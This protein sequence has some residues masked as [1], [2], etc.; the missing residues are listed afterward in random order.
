[1]E[2]PD[3]NYDPLF[4][5]WSELEPAKNLPI[6]YG[7][8]KFVVQDLSEMPAID[9]LHFRINAALDSRY[10]FDPRRN[11]I[12]LETPRSGWK[13]ICGGLAVTA[14]IA[15]N[16]REG[17]TLE[18]EFQNDDG[19]VQQVLVPNADLSGASPAAVRI[20]RD[21]GLYIPGS[22][23]DMAEFLRSWRPVR[24]ESDFVLPGWASDGSLAFGLRDGRVVLATDA[25][26]ASGQKNAF[27]YDAEELKKWKTEVASKFSGNPV[28]LFF[29]SVGLCGPLVKPLQRP[30]F[31]FNVVMTT[32]RGKTSL[33]EV[34]SKLWPD[35]AVQSWDASMAAVQDFSVE[36]ADSLLILDEAPLDRPLDLARMIMLLGNGRPRKSRSR[37]DQSAVESR[38]TNWTMPFI[39][40]SERSIGTLKTITR[41]RG[42]IQS[43]VFVRA[44]DIVQSSEEVEIWIDHHGAESSYDFLKGLG[45]ALGRTDQIAGPAFVQALVNRWSWVLA[46]IGQRE[47]R[48]LK[49]LETELGIDHESVQGGIA[50]VLA[51]FVA[52]AL[53]GQ[54]AS[55]LEIIPQGSEE[56]RLAIFEVAKQWYQGT[57]SQGGLAISPLENLRAW[58]ASHGQNKLAEIDNAGRPIR[59]RATCGGWQDDEYLYLLRHTL[60]TAVGDKVEFSHAVR[61]L[62]NKEIIVPGGS[63]G[64]YQYKMGSAVNGRPNVYRISRTALSQD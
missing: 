29:L 26:R 46:E 42:G 39:S 6:I 25:T 3:P 31:G 20:L 1:M 35:L 64:S 63:S 5:L 62:V 13:K 33:L 9:R 52:V 7:S 47:E 28:P 45:A 59:N 21:N 43:G 55:E 38:V 19:Q 56:V 16:H 36:A 57:L 4:K 41:G 50:R 40:S 12:L 14:L 58:I 54:L 8:D 15:G 10:R 17:A 37:P 60:E 24:R 30:T 49:D 61:Q 34:I 11:L 51:Y 27:T 32:S 23:R 44:V 22:N 18:I 48:T 53:A 2:E